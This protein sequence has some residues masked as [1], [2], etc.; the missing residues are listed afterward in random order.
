[1]IKDEKKSSIRD[2]YKKQIKES[3]ISVREAE[4]I[5]KVGARSYYSSKIPKLRD[6]IKVYKFSAVLVS[7][8]TALLVLMSVLTFIFHEN[9]LDVTFY[10]L[11]GIT[12]ALVLYVISCFAI[13]I[14]ITKKK[15]QKYTQ[16]IKE[17]NEQDKIKQN[18][19]YDYL[20]KNRAKQQGEQL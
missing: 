6:G 7:I 10:V 12:I 13:L 5:Q 11:F 3:K 17:I 18:A 19:L 14:P 15:I 16:K 20:L 2:D 4:A 8:T 9:T 1:M